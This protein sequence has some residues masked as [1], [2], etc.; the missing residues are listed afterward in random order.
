VLDLARV[1]P[2]ETVLDIGCGTGT[3]AIAAG[4]RVGPA[5][6]VFGIDA[7]PE[8]IARASGK[9]RKAGLEIDLRRGI[10]EALPFPDAHFDVV[11]STLVLHHLPRKARE[12]C[13]QEVLR[14]L[15]PGGRVLAVDFGIASRKRRG[16][17]AH[18]HRRHGHVELSR[19]VDLLRGARLDVVESG[20]VGIQ[21]LNFVLATTPGHS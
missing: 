5:G 21:D 12:Q 2:G 1:V 18:L 11:L 13:A 3:L 15:K 20:A 4:R 17:L 9:V 6:S 7:S 14:V 19:I 10:V 8:M 16:L